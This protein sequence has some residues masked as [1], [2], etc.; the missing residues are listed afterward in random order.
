MEKKQ[1]KPLYEFY[2]DTATKENVLHYLVQFLEEEAV[3]KVFNKED[4]SAVAEA[5]EVIDKAFDNMDYIFGA[6]VAKKEQTNEAR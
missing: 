4:V 1:P 2:K 5:K 3:K 6:K